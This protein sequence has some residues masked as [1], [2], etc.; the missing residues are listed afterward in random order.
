MWGVR[1]VYS[2]DMVLINASGVAVALG[3][4]GATVY[5]V[6]RSSS[7]SSSKSPSETIEETAALVTARG[8]KGVA[9]VLDLHHEEELQALIER[10]RQQEA[11]L[12]VAVIAA[13]GG[14]ARVQWGLPFWEMDVSR[15]LELV[16]CTQQILLRCCAAV[17]PL[18][19][20]TAANNRGSY[21]LLIGLSDGYVL[22]VAIL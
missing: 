4:E 13:W 8:G 20:F 16:H 19:R 3:E 17:I 22:I 10:I 1:T 12:D 7:L 9:V 15:G 14:D 2:S 11:R 18:L 21:P 5:C 6:G